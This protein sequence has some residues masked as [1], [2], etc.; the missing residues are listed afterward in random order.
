MA[1]PFLHPENL[2]LPSSLVPPL[3]HEGGKAIV[4]KA[5]C[6]EV[7]TPPFSLLLYTLI[8]QP[9]FSFLF[10]LYSY[11]LHLSSLPYYFL[12]PSLCS[13]LL[14]LLSID[15]WASVCVCTPVWLAGCRRAQ[16]GVYVT[17]ARE[18]VQHV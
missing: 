6:F 15:N 10:S 8:T 1:K 4:A 16:W 11:P 17:K 12:S 3:C 5:V 2:P 13:H 9:P 14:L 7:S 18:D